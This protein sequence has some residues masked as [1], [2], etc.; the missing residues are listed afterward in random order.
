[1]QCDTRVSVRVSHI[2]YGE[3]VD[4]TCDS[5]SVGPVVVGVSSRTV[6]S[7]DSAVHPVD[8]H[9]DILVSPIGAECGQ[10]KINDPI[11]ICVDAE[12]LPV[13]PETVAVTICGDPDH[14]HEIIE[15]RISKVRQI[16]PIQSEPS[17][18][19]GCPH[20]IQTVGIASWVA[21]PHKL[22]VGISVSLGAHPKLERCT[23][24]EGLDTRCGGVGVECYAA[25]MLRPLLAQDL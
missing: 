1:M 16:L 5:C 2:G 11:T 19:G 22:T 20:M 14:D 23:G 13:I 8:L 9:K 12:L 18:N 15:V 7:S 25:A 10:V 4:H 3:R 24:I 21:S 6:A 17:R